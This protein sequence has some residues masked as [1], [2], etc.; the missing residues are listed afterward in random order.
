METLEFDLEK[1]KNLLVTSGFQPSQ[2]LSIEANETHVTYPEKNPALLVVKPYPSESRESSRYIEIVKLIELAKHNG[3][4]IHPYSKGANL[5]YGGKEPYGP[6]C[7]A[8]DLSAFKRI[9]NYERKS[10]HITIE[11]G[12]SQEAISEFLK[13][14]GDIY[15]HDTTGAPKFASVIGNYLERGF[16]HTPHAEH[17]K[18][19]LHA[20][21]ITPNSKGHPPT[22]FVTST[23]GTSFQIDG[24]MLHRTYNIGPDLTGLI[25]QNNVSIVTSLTIKLLKKPE[26]FIAYFI[27]FKNEDTDHMIEACAEL[28]KQNTIHSAAH[29]GNNM[30]T[31]QLLAVEFPELITSYD[32][33]E[34]NKLINMYSLD[35]WTLSG[36]MYGTPNQVKAHIKDLKASMKK[37]G[38]RPLFIGKRKLNL[39]NRSLSLSPRY[40]RLLVK[41]LVSSG[42]ITLRKIGA[43]LALRKSLIELCKIKQGIPSNEFLR[44]IYWRNLHKLSNNTLSPTQD[45]VGLLWGAPCSQISSNDFNVITSIMNRTCKKY[46]LESPISVTLINDRTM[47]CVLSLS[48]NR[49]DEKQEHSALSCYKEIMLECASLGF[50]QYRMSTFSNQFLTHIHLP[51]PYE[52]PLVKSFFD[53]CNVIS[54]SKYCLVSNN[55]TNYNDQ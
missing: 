8:L 13:K 54:P 53:P 52:L 22:Q 10:G 40:N 41:K 42:S 37:L 15:I 51:L 34:L 26:C 27:P 4:A 2:V 12:V 55:F 43:K 30:K 46:N 1:L 45:K 48:W 38:V 33:D 50:L 18:N 39:I 35:D 23:D 11:P 19:I 3:F 25:I 20:E 24:K 36:G 14:N 5:G 6:K 44:T 16:G 28:R 21:I 9:S 31:L 32:L 29:I 17:A 49:E 47:E 7:I